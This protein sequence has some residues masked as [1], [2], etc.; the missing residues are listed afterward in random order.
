MF[1]A[2]RWIIL[3][4]ILPVVIFMSASFLYQAFGGGP[5]AHFDMIEFTTALIAGLMIFPLEELGWRSFAL[6]RVFESLKPVA[7]FPAPAAA[8]KPA[9]KAGAS[10]PP[11]LT[12]APRPPS[13]LEGII[14]PSMMLGTMTA[15]FRAPLFLFLEP[16]MPADLSPRGIG[17]EITYYIMGMD[18]LNIVITV[19][20]LRCNKTTTAAVIFSAAVHASMIAIQAT[21]VGKLFSYVSMASVPIAAVL[22][23]RAPAFMDAAA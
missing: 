1:K 2:W 3:S 22:I 7:A 17:R 6:P 10:R 4:L 8:A 21:H 14:V 12:Q 19:I 15:L 11:K 23:S 9:T 5:A 18:I 20:W 13:K 16:F